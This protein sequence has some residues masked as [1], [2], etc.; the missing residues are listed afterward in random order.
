MHGITL[1]NKE[2]QLKID[3]VNEIS[4]NHTDSSKSFKT[5]VHL[6]EHQRRQNFSSE[7][8]F[9]AA[10]CS[11]SLQ[12]IHKYGNQNG[13]N[14]IGTHADVTTVVDTNKSKIKRIVLDIYLT[15]SLT[16][17]QLQDLRLKIDSSIIF[18]ALG[19]S[20]LFEFRVHKFQEGQQ[21]NN[22]DVAA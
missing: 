1:N 7:D 17:D 8:L 5:S 4:V 16:E 19:P 11:A 14:F 15:V 3:G 9:A 18:G 2:L 20:V 6:G 13:I 22:P 12:N 21:A 10:L